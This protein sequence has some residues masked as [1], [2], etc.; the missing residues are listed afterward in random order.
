MCFVKAEKKL[1]IGLFGARADNG[2]LGAQ[3][4][5]LYK[6]LKPTK[7]LI[8]D[9]SELNG[10]ENHF[11]RYGVLEYNPT[12][13]VYKTPKGASE[14]VPKDVIDRFLQG[15]NLVICCEIPYNYYL[16]AKAREMGVKTV[17]QYNYEF[18]DYLNNS[19]L[20]LPD[21]LLAPS[22][23]HFDDVVAK[24]G[25]KCRV[26]YL[27]VPVNR[28]VLPFT[29]RHEAKTFVHV[30]GHDLFKDRNGTGIV[31]E[32]MRKVKSNIKLIIYTQHELG[33]YQ[34]A[35]A[36]EDSRIEVR[37]MDIKNYWE[38]YNEGDV[39]LL[40]RKYGG[41]SLQLNEAMSVGMVPI[42]T[43]VSPQDAILHPQCLVNPVMMEHI[44]TRA[45]IECYDIMPG[46]LADKI[47]YFNSMSQDRIEELSNYS[48]KVA[49]SIS[50]NNLL[51]L[52][53]SKF[54]GLL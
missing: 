32:A 54:E 39:L 8:M 11:E 28:E 34:M 5:E 2:G 40:P 48:N 53:F 26:E 45:L 21:M 52:Y 31:L 3:T 9:I 36:M 7:T 50:W 10:N 41:L 51:P 16:I 29:Q 35:M 47:D 19:R 38:L 24:F 18:L 30:A 49:N 37:Q 33:A 12:V 20:P 6:H 42:M 22:R 44:K 1:K 13:E 27:P 15:V 23:W 43:N 4:W 25:D 46:N 14:L 17:I